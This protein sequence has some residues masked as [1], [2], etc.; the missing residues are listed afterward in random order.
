MNRASLQPHNCMEVD[1][2]YGAFP[3]PFALFLACQL[4][5]WIVNDV[6]KQSQSVLSV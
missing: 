4:H 2:Q 6:Q 1:E 3:I 5:L